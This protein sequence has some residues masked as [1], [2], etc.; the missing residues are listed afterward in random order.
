MQS[1]IGLT[2][3]GVLKYF[4]QAF[5]HFHLAFGEASGGNIPHAMLIPIQ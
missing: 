3:M 4:C 2:K 5:A 1:R